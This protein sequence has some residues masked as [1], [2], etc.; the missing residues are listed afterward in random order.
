M[1]GTCISE[2]LEAP[3]EFNDIKDAKDAGVR[4]IPVV[5]VFMGP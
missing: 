5:V 3:D 1:I 4:E 2:E